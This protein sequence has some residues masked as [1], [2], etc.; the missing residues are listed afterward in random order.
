LAGQRIAIN[1]LLAGEVSTTILLVSAKEVRQK[2]SGEPYLSLTLADRSGDIDAKMWDNVEEVMSA[3]DR[4]DFVKVRGVMQLYQ[5]RPQFTIHKLARIQDENELEMADFFPASARDPQEM[6][7]ELNSLIAGMR[8]PHLQQL[9]TS[10]FADEDIAR[11]FRM[12]PAAKSIHHAWLGGLLE[13]VLSLSRLAKMTSA[14]YQPDV[15]EDL[16]MA[17]VI[18]HDIGKIYELSYQR[19]FL[20]TSEGQ[21]LGHI[22]LAL[23]MLAD[24]LAHL[25]EF[26]HTLRNLLE[27]M[28]IS[29][30][31]ELEY[32]S[33]K[34][35]VFLEAMLLHHLDNLDSK[36]ETI[37]VN[38]RKDSV[39]ET[40]WTTWVP[41]L[42]RTLLKKDRYLNAVPAP[43]TK[44]AALKP[45]IAPAPKQASLLG[46]KL[47]EALKKN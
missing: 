2:K 35:P 28:I 1:A 20:Y 12:A 5:N 25:P 3:F 40:E 9:L 16:L 24:K 7:N 19:S 15:D 44:A 34:V 47:S 42:E 43:A 4:D 29:H 13:H 10:I 36:M 17:G 18:L 27:H 26:P 33:P 11:R 32:G 22:M 14:H 23:R 6:W 31:G 41:S 46:D 8:N 39:A 45:A 21:L 37:R 38:V 30:H